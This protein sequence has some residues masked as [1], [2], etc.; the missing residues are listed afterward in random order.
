MLS[1]VA[2]SGPWG[3][4]PQTSGV[5]HDALE[6]ID[7]RRQADE[8]PGSSSEST[9]DSSDVLDKEKADNE[10]HRLAHAV[11]QHSIKS[12]GGTYHNPFLT[13]EDPALDPRSGQ[14]SPEAWTRTLIGLQSRDPERYPE[15][16]AGVGYQNLNVH[17][18]GSLTDYQKTFGNYPLSLAGL[19]NSITGRGKRKIQILRDFEGLVKSGEMLVV[20][21]RPGSGCS[22]LLKTLAGETHGFFIDEGTHIN[23]QGIPMETMHSDFRGE[24]IYQAE[25]DVH[26]P[27]LT[28]GQTL[29]FAAQARTPRNRIP[30]VSRETY[31]S[32]MTDVI[33]AVFGISHTY[34]TKVGNDFVRGVSGGERKRVSIAE[35]AL[36]GSPLQCWDNSTRGLDSATALEFVRTLRLSTNLAGS[37]AAVAIYQASQ[38]I[39]DIFD[40]VVVL[41]EGRQI[42]F[43][44]TKAAKEFFVDMGFHCTERATTGDFLTS[45]TNPAER[46]VRE[47]FEH[48]V[49]RTPDEFAARW[50]SSKARAQLLKE[51]EDFDRAYPVGGQQLQN[52]KHARKAQ[53]AK[54]Q[55]VKSP[56]TLSMPMQVRLCMKRGFQRLRGDASLALTGSIGNSVMAIIIGSCFY[57]MPSNTGS[58]YSRGALLFFA[59]LLNAFSSFLEIL[60]LYA[61]R[62]IVEKQSKYAFYH[63]VSEAV[64]SMICGLPEKILTSILFNVTLYFLTNLR[65][66]PG[67]FFTF[68]LFS[69]VCTLAMS[70][71]FRTIGALSKTLAQ[72]MAPA[73]VFILALIIYTGFAV[74]IRDMHPWFR[75]INYLDPVAYAFEALMVNEF[76]NRR[77]NCSAFVPQGPGYESLSPDERLCSAVGAA[78]VQI[79]LKVTPTSTVVSAITVRTYGEIWVSL[80]LWS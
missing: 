73:A 6:K 72:A 16:V 15:R 21:G 71:L 1:S 23:Y 66:T 11:T 32:H 53:Q 28:V 55:R 64:A 19:F 58:F 30:G 37:T 31:A 3:S 39:Y 60:T 24:C 8:K 61:Q 43:G 54:R 5:A 51:I 49:P 36:G 56:Y 12:A 27:Q 14:F 41:Y 52:F 48:L 68:Y 78:L 35:A 74:P 13:T 79:M 69:F 77:F 20:L 67:A 26:F 45:L 47:G 44:S 40:K 62:P 29:N 65:R 9:G 59:I 22:T 46:I 2:A 18:F 25:I 34:N 70:M 50:Q 80:S 42:Y 57:N 75:W 33:M 7:S 10:V 63:P 17:G 38:S 76:H 4:I